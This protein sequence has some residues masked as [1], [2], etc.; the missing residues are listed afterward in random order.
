MAEHGASPLRKLDRELCEC[1]G[2]M[3][4]GVGRTARRRALD[5]YVTGLLLDGKRN[6]T[7]PMAARLPQT[8]NQTEALCSTG[9]S[10]EKVAHARLKSG[11]G[12]QGCLKGKLVPAGADRRIH[13]GCHRDEG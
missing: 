3:T 10:R 2:S 9:A 8:P 5:G 1:L 7:A 6:N 13:L 12:C 11:D 4:V